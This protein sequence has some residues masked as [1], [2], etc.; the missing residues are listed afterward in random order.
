MSYFERTELQILSRSRTGLG[1][2][3]LRARIMLMAG[4]GESNRQIAAQFNMKL[5]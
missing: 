3:A 2:V 4:E 5:D 1:P